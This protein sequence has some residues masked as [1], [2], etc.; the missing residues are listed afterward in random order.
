MVNDSKPFLV[1]LIRAVVVSSFVS[2]LYLFP[3]LQTQGPERYYLLHSYLAGKRN[4]C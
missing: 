2:V 3:S 1:E 4:W